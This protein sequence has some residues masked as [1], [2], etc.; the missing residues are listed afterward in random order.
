MFFTA[1]SADELFC[2]RFE[3]GRAAVYEDFVS[4]RSAFNLSRFWIDLYRQFHDT[5]LVC[6][7][8]NIAN[9]A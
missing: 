9:V 6:L 3:K 8:I 1:G 2:G 5:R 4:A 7:G